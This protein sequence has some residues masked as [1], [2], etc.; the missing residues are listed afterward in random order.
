MR[1]NPLVFQ[2]N[3][4]MHVLEG[5]IRFDGTHDDWSHTFN[6]GDSFLSPRAL[7]I[8]GSATV[9]SARFPASFG[10]GEFGRDHA[11]RAAVCAS[12]NQRFVIHEV[13][14]LREGPA[15]RT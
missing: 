14:M 15:L 3:E 2:S 11:G 6:A 9:T 4:F 1:T 5:S 12:N 7:T 8:N 10:Q 13:I